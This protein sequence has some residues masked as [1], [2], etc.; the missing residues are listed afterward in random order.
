MLQESVR[1]SKTQMGQ[2]ALKPGVSRSKVA[3]LATL[4]LKQLSN[5]M[6]PINNGTR[7]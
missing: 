7:I 1:I 3:F 6:V 2:L 4:G 5:F